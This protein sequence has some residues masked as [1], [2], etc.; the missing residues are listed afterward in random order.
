MGE[1][2]ENWRGLDELE[3]SA[4]VQAEDSSIRV[5]REF[6]LS[7]FVEFFGASG[8]SDGILVSV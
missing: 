3:S 7:C 2:L 4:D 1:Y 6:A 5:A 8:T